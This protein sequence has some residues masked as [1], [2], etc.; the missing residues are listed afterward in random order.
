MG[1]VRR[2]SRPSLVSSAGSGVCASSLAVNMV[3][4]REMRNQSNGFVDETKAITLVENWE[5]GSM[6]AMAIL[7]QLTLQK[8]DLNLR[9]ASPQAG[10]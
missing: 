8:S 9:V 3:S 5:S 7:H 6:R 4:A 2:A 10:L 1:G